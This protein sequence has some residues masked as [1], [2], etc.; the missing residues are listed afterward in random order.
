MFAKEL[1]IEGQSSVHLEEHG[2]HLE[3][4]Q[5]V[6]VIKSLVVGSLLTPS[7]QLAQEIGGEGQSIDLADSLLWDIRNHV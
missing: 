1:N 3:N 6:I 2:L 5:R 7:H 4:I